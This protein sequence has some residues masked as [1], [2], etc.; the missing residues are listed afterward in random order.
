MAGIIVSCGWM[1]WGRR[2]STA[3]YGRFTAR[4]AW[5]SVHST[6]TDVPI[7]VTGVR[8]HGCIHHGVRRWGPLS[9]HQRVR[10]AHTVVVV[11]SIARTVATLGSGSRFSSC[12]LAHQPSIRWTSR[13]ASSLSSANGLSSTHGSAVGRGLPLLA[14]SLQLLSAIEI[15]RR[16]R[17]RPTTS[18]RA[19]MHGRAHSPHT[20]RTPPQRAPL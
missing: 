8:V 6:S 9:H 17:G 2:I 10:I 3:R 14:L 20:T 5:T 18:R 7:P 11:G 4:T 15:R 16:R 13:A 1:R 19:R 12:L